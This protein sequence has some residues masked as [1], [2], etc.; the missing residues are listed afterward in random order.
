[1]HIVR[2][3]FLPQGQCGSRK[4]PTMMELRNLAKTMTNRGAIGPEIKIGPQLQLRSP[5]W[6]MSTEVDTPRGVR[7]HRPQATHRHR[8]GM[9]P[10]HRH[11]RRPRQPTW[12]Q[13]PKKRPRQ[14]ARQ[15]T[16]RLHRP[17]QP[18]RSFWSE[19]NASM[20]ERRS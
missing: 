11:R 9:Q 12:S 7:V 19:S 6:L 1:M 3:L 8:R 14:P 16:S 4:M 18:A 17:R 20:N 13:S 10:A 5:Q 2:M 15:P